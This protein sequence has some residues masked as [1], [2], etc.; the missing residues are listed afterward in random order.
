MDP[1]DLGDGLTVWVVHGHLCWYLDVTRDWSAYF[2]Q[3]KRLATRTLKAEET[4]DSEPWGDAHVDKREAAF[5]EIIGS[6]WRT[7]PKGWEYA[8]ELL[9]ARKQRIFDR[10][11]EAN[12]RAK[13]W[14]NAQQTALA[15]D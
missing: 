2:R 4:T 13:E 12:Q 10:Y 11:A 5:E 7:A 9:A 15:A 14:H 6:T 8:I 3:R 1:V